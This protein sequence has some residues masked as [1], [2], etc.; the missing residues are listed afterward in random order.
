MLVIGILVIVTIGVGIF[1]MQQMSREKQLEED[2]SRLA[3][4]LGKPL[5]TADKLQQQYQEVMQALEPIARKDVLD[6]IISIAED[7]GIDVN[8]EAD[9]LHIPPQDSTGKEKVGETTYQVLPINGLVVQAEHSKVI[10]FI[11]KL[12]SR[13]KLPTLVIRQMVIGHIVTREGSA[14][15]VIIEVPETV[16]TLNLAIYSLSTSPSK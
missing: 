16:A 10:D 11:A 5:A 4:T 14:G 7:S 12:E 6:I 2:V 13:N 1:Y 15:G 3:L 8:P 9:K